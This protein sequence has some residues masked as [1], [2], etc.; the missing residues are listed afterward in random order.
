[1]KCF[2][3]LLVLSLCACTKVPESMIGQCFKHKRFDNTFVK[4]ASITTELS[5]ASVGYCSVDGEGEECSSWGLSEFQELYEEK[6]IDCSLY[7]DMAN[8]SSFRRTARMLDSLKKDA[9]HQAELII[10]LESRVKKLE[11]KE[12]K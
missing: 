12:A 5:G 7:N 6:S 1:M 8:K 9:L 3:I 4:V 11:K 2:S 10:N